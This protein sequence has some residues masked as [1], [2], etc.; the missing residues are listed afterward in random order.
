M[1]KITFQFDVGSLVLIH[2]EVVHKSERNLSEYSRHA[3]TF[4]AIERA[5]TVYSTD[6]W[7]QPT[8]Q[9]PFPGVLDN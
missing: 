4:H 2:G 7:L 6:N 8:D 5:E 3:Y 9:L 1:T